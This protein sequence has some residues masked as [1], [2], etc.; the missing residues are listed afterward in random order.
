MSWREESI[1]IYKALN[2]FIIEEREE[3]IDSRATNVYIYEEEAGD[4]HVVSMLY[5]IVSFLKLFNSENGK[6]NL[7]IEWREENE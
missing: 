6:R 1:T 3:N 7:V 4:E 2:G 5:A